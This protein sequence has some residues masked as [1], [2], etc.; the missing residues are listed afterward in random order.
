MNLVLGVLDKNPCE[1]LSSPIVTENQRGASEISWESKE[2][3]WQI[4]WTSI[5]YELVNWQAPW[6]FMKFG[7][8]IK[9][10]I[11]PLMLFLTSNWDVF[12]DGEVAYYYLVGT[13]YNYYLYNH[14]DPIINKLN[15][16]FQ[17]IVEDDQIY[18]Y[19]CFK[20]ETVL[21]ILTLFIMLLPGILLSFLLLHGLK[22]IQSKIFLWIFIVLISPVI[23]LFFPLLLFLTKVC[24]Y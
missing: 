6:N 10:T 22:I 12:S 18:I 17:G 13:Y 24:E 15:C 3:V 7:E 16:T 8:L 2:N 14:S 21:G 1:I 9:T 20:R 23:S 5:N 19:K 11:V 4:N